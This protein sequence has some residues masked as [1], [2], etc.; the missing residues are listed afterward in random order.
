MTFAL[1]PLTSLKD[2][3]ATDWNAC[4]T[5]TGQP[6]NPFVSH[7]FLLALELSGSATLKTGWAA[8]HLRATSRGGA[9]LAAPAIT[10]A[11]VPPMSAAPLAADQIGFVGSSVAIPN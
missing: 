9:P 2:I 8:Q 10:A 7:E 4:A 1:R 5:A 3:S 11:N 6:Y